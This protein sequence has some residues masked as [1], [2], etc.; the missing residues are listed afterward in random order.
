MEIKPG[1]W[2]EGCLDIATGRVL[3]KRCEVTGYA[4]LLIDL[5]DG[6]VLYHQMH[7]DFSYEAVLYDT[8]PDGYYR[9]FLE[10]A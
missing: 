2:H 9:F 4:F 7:P 10:R 1:Q 5:L 6:R 8:L 3:P